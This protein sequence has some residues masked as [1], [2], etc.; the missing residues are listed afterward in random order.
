M[1]EKN[2]VKASL[3]PFF[4]GILRERMDREKICATECLRAYMREAAAGGLTPLQRTTARTA[5][6]RLATKL[7]AD[8]DLMLLAQTLGLGG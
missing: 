3:G 8:P 4:M 6:N 2:H 7:P 5:L 1:P